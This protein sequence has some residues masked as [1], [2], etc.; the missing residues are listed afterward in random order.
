[1]SDD[2]GLVVEGVGLV[3]AVVAAAVALASVVEGEEGVVSDAVAV[4]VV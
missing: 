4:A 2:R 3:F 1:V